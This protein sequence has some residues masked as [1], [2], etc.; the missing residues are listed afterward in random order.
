GARE[1]R[2]VVPAVERALDAIEHDE[3]QVLLH[4]EVNRLPAKYRASVVLCYF[5][6]RTHDEAAAALHWPVGTVRGRLARA[7]DLLRVR[8]T[9]RGLVQS[10]WIGA[11]LLE[12]IAP[13]EPPARLPQP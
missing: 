9:R 12:P 3:L 5:E 13:I 4:E 8:L 10:G 11:T 6:G 7:R 1:R 2:A